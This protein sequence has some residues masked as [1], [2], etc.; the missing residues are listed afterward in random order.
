MANKFTEQRKRRNSANATEEF[1][2][3]LY[4]DEETIS[5]HIK[6][7]DRKTAQ[8]SDDIPV[9]RKPGRPKLEDKEA[10]SVYSILLT[11]SIREKMDLASR[12][13]K[14]S[15]K[16]YIVKLIEDDYNNNGEKYEAFKELSE[17][18]VF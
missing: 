2:E 4:E 11:D 14:L 8:E 15:I 5:E 6:D 9:K 7:N 3:K 16:K 18:I 13:R 17:K 1:V 12:A 10:S